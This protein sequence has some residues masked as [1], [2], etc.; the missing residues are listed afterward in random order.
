MMRDDPSYMFSYFSEEQ[1]KCAKT[2]IIDMNFLRD[3]KLFCTTILR[4]HAIV[5][6]KKRK[7]CAKTIIIDKQL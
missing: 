6:I 1:K 2:I 3:T 5:S 7:Y 4:T